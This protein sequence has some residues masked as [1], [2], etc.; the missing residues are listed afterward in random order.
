MKVKRARPLAVPEKGHNEALLR[1]R[2]SA[3]TTT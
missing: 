2:A 1:G 3:R